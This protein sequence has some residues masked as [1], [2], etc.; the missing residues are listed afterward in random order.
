MSTARQ[1]L[2]SAL[3]DYKRSIVDLDEIKSRLTRA[4]VTMQRAVDDTSLSGNEAALKVIAAQVLGTRVTNKE[5]QR[6][7][8][9]TELQT[10]I[11]AAGQELNSCVQ[12]LYLEKRE[13]IVNDVLG[14]LQ[15]N[16][17][18]NRYQLEDVIDQDIR[19]DSIRAPQVTPVSP[20][21]KEKLTQDPVQQ[22]TTSDGI[23]DVTTDRN[24]KATYEPNIEATIRVAELI[25]SN[26]EKLTL[27]ET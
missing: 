16:D 4:Q 27:E 10:T 1:L 25:L 22:Y 11:Y 21:V 2:E 15:T 13:T 24:I 17:M 3:S 6:D 18:F 12:S 9:Y 7:N 23:I 8:L 19:L 5:S 20:H 26:F 14:V